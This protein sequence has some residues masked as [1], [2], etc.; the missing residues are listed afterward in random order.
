MK[1]KIFAHIRV[2]VFV[3]LLGIVLMRVNKI[4]EPVKTLQNNYYPNT[5]TYKGFYKMEPNSIDVLFF[6]SSVAVNAF[7]PQVIYD[8]YGITSY[9]LGSEQQSILLSYFWL[10]EALNYQNPKVVVIDTRFMRKLH[11]GYPCNTTE[12]LT[13][14][15]IDPMRLS[16]V[17]VEA[18]RDIC[19]LDNQ[20]NEL[21]YYLLNI[22]FHDRWKSLKESDVDKFAIIDKTKGYAPEYGKGPDEY[23]TFDSVDLEVVAELDEIMLDYLD[24]MISLCNENNIQLVLVSLPGNEMND[25]INN[26]Y[27]RLAE[28]D[29][30]DY[31]NFCS[32]EQYSKIGAKL[33]EE[34][35]IGH[36]NVWGAIK[37]SKYIGEILKDKYGLLAHEDYQYESSRD[38]WEG[39]VDNKKLKDTDD[40]LS[41]LKMLDSKN[42]DVFIVANGGARIISQ[43][44]RA[45]LANLGVKTDLWE[46]QCESFYAVFK[47]GELVDEVV[48]MEEATYIETLNDSNIIVEMHSK[49]YST[50]PEDNLG[51]ISVDGVDYVGPEHAYS[52]LVFDNVTM[53]VVDFVRIDE[54][55]VVRIQ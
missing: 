46:H 24:K 38:Y 55:N 30:V 14:N 29:T 7:I 54:E 2:I 5:S 35:V 4:L 51:T 47:S 20:Q 18:I 22:R 12:G 43:D 8:E 42:Y 40:S 1:Q 36:Q 3:I 41:Y 37:T 16:S 17:K 19:K 27:S 15:C 11:Y 53:R 45:E 10:K 50:G 26:F 44:V 25:G 34:S 6:G 32:T 31:L 48:S 49:G 21:S 23:K 28:N 9:N 13:R 52:I 33:P 39:I